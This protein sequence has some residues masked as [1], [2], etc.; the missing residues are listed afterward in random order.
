MRRWWRSSGVPDH[1]SS[2]D[3][4]ASLTEPSQSSSRLGTS[5]LSFSLV[6]G[7]QPRF[8]GS[9]Q[10]KVMDVRVVLLT[11]TK[12]AMYVCCRCNALFPAPLVVP[13][14]RSPVGG[15]ALGVAGRHPGI[16]PPAGGHQRRQLHAG[17]RQVLGHADTSAS[18]SLKKSVHPQDS[19]LPAAAVAP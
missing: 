11:Y 5:H 19:Q 1:F 7:S 16:L 10:P 8:H 15:L 6:V 18:L 13:D 2:T 12:I 14:H 17:G 9:D 3:R 4:R